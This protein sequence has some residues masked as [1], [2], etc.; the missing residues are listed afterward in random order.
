[1]IS[2]V[3]QNSNYPSANN[4]RTANDRS[5]SNQNTTTQA[6][7]SV[8]SAAV[9]E[10]SQASN[11]APNL[12][13]A[14]AIRNQMELASQNLIRLITQNFQRQSASSN[15]I[16]PNLS[17]AIL[18]REAAELVSEDGFWGV[19][20]TSERLFDLAIA[21]SGGDPEKMEVMRG[22]IKRG[23]AAAERAFGGELPSISHDTLD[24]V[25]QRLDEW[26][27]NNA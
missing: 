20:Q 6:N 27:S 3:I 26:Q 5:K 15:I 16:D 23:F 12:D 18:Q 11:S 22:A 2:Q 9:Y 25:M 17:D 1:M 8:G 4:N 14:N 13:A 24:A 19:E 21:F 7:N 10:R